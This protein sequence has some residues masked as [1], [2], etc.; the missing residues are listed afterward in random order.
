MIEPLRRFGPPAADLV[1]RQPYLTHQG[2]FDA[3]VPHHWGYY[4]KSHYLP[5]LSDGAINVLMS[6]AWKKRSPASYTIMFHMGGAIARRPAD[7]SAAGGRDAAHAM[8]INAAW[9]EGGPQHPDIGWCREYFA[10]MQPYATGGVYVNFL[11]NDEGE[12]RIRASYGDRYERLARIK[13]LYDPDNVFRSNQ[14][15]QPDPAGIVAETR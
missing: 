7:F 5:P 2:F 6:H 12:A 9:P 3:S 13:A 8:N 4:W 10:A 11:H 14:N 1:R 15:I